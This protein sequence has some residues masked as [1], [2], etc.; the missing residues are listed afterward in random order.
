MRTNLIEY[1]RKF[2]QILATN[3]IF[4]TIES[5]QI[6]FFISTSL[7][8]CGQGVEKGVARVLDT[9]RMGCGNRG[10]LFE[11]RILLNRNTMVYER[12]HKQRHGKGKK[13]QYLVR[14]KGYDD[15]QNT[16][17]P[18]ENIHAPELIK[19]FHATSPTAIKELRTKGSKK[20]KRSQKTKV[21]KP[22]LDE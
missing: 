10:H 9:E 5:D 2:I 18:V 22:T 21:E 6:H 1:S 16:W 14:W 13:L 19:P 3:N 11:A 4:D 12:A 20:S 8:C 7:L 15:S 17:E